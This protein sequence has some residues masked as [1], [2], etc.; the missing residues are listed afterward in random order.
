M[1]PT[2]KIIK[3]CLEECAKSTFKQKVGAIIFDKNQIISRGYN[4]I[5]DWN[6]LNKKMNLYYPG[7]I[8]AELDAINKCKNKKDISRSNI[9]I[10][11]YNFKTEKFKFSKPCD[12]CGL[13]LS[14]FNIRNIYYSIEEFPFIIECSKSS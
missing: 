6:K 11:R 12:K 1:I 5:N 13:L 4:K 9:L 2:Q 8:H 7:S 3:S 14:Y 10:I